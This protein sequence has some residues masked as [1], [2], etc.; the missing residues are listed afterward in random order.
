[1]EESGGRSIV[2]LILME[3][4]TFGAHLLEGWVCRRTAMD[5]NLQVL[6]EIEQGFLGSPALG[7]ITTSTTLSRFTA[8]LRI[9]RILTFLNPCIV[10]QL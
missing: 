4:V 5:R 9:A 1:M 8:Q 6:T 7:S 2:P 3:V 10:I